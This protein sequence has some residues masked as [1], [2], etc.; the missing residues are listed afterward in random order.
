MKIQPDDHFDATY[1]ADDETPR[2]LLYSRLTACIPERS[3]SLL[4]NTA[5]DRTDQVK[6]DTEN[7]DGSIVTVFALDDPVASSYAPV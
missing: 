2:K 6:Q 7:D 3:D 5:N 4:G 1:T